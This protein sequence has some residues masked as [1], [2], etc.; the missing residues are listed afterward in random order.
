MCWNTPVRS[1]DG[2]A[3]MVWLLPHHRKGPS[4]APRWGVFDAETAQAEGP[5]ALP[6]PI[7]ASYAAPMVADEPV[8]GATSLEAN[9]C[10][11]LLRSSDVGLLAVAIGDRPDI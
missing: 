10:W 5:S 7:P 4:S 3:C 1:S 8:P 11:A 2:I 9:M 6:G